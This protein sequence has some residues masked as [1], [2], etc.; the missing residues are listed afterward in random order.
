MIIGLILLVLNYLIG[1]FVVFLL[2]HISIIYVENSQ[3]LAN[4]IPENI[5]NSHLEIYRNPK[6]LDRLWVP[7]VPI[8]NIYQCYITIIA[9]NNLNEKLKQ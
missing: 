3:V 4:T 1:R 2:I 9:I 5:Y 8:F 6:C 7:H